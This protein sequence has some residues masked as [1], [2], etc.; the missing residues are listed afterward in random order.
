MPTKKEIKKNQKAIEGLIKEGIEKMIEANPR[1][2]NYKGY[3]LRHADVKGV[4]NMFNE[5]YEVSREMGYNSQEAR[6]KAISETRNYISSGSMLDEK[7]KKA[8]LEQGSYLILDEKSKK[9]I[10]REGKLERSLLQKITRPFKKTEGTNYLDRTTETFNELLYIIKEGGYNVPEVEKPLEKLHYLGFASPAIALLAESKLID[11]KKERYLLK[12]LYETHKQYT[13]EV[14][15]GIEKYVVPQKI[16]AAVIG[17]IGTFFLIFNLNMTGAVIGGDSNVT[18]G[19]L[20]VFMIFFALM[21]YLR[22]LKKSF[23]K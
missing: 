3:F 21:L 23:K 10:K 20:G 2:A 19:I 7:G 15:S 18:M 14:V 17:F 12:N 13:K 8:L 16:A 22:P 1:F 11:K 5:I 9:L 4:E 6:N